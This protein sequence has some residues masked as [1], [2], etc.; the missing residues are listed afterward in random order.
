M[1]SLP[2][3]HRRHTEALRG[4]AQLDLMQAPHIIHS[5]RCVHFLLVNCIHF[6][7]SLTSSTSCIT[8]LSCF[9]S[10]RSD[11]L[12]SPSSLVISVLLATVHNYRPNFPQH[13]LH[14]RIRPPRPRPPHSMKATISAVHDRAERHPTK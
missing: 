14:R 3:L 1:H 10:T 11:V 13:D 9:R 12:R 4:S 8:S 6:R 5:Y 7:R 2:L